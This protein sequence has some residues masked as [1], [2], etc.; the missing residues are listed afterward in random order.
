MTT[1]SNILSQGSLAKVHA[2]LS[3]SPY[4]DGRVSG[5][6]AES[7]RNLE[8]AA[9][10]ERYVE[11][12]TIVETA[13][14]DNVEFNLTAF[15]RYLTRPIISRYHVGMYYKE[16]VDQPIMGFM[17]QGKTA[18]KGFSGHGQNYVRSDLSMTLFLS[19]PSTYDGGELTFDGPAGTI[20]T[21]LEAGSAV[22]YPTG[23]PHSV[24]PVTRGT[25]DA[26]VFWIQT[27]FPLEAHRQAVYDARRLH[28]ALKARHPDSPESALAETIF[29][30]LCR[31]FAEI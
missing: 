24:A 20:R 30:N 1:I 28:E 9:D 23:A 6:S 15:P 5:G 2:I 21:K 26:A 8:L 17:A 12:L 10:D 22:V 4:V 14:R 19:D 31:L 16:H 13:V 27:M 11:I 7:K 29:F 3:S 18:R 25:R